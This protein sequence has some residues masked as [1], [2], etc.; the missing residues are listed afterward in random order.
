MSIK[1]KLKAQLPW[2]EH[3]LDEWKEVKKGITLEELLK[4]LT[5]DK[6]SDNML[7]TVNSKIEKKNYVLSDGD[8]IV[9]YPSFIGG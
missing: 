8:K 2:E 6:M 5:I 3:T 7:Y 1:V 9:I 4:Q